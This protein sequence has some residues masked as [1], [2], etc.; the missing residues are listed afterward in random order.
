MGQ[1][2][3]GGASAGAFGL[4]LAAGP[5]V[6]CL[7]LQLDCRRTRRRWGY[8][9]G[10]RTGPADDHTGLVAGPAFVAD[11]C[12]LTAVGRGCRDRSV[13]RR[14]DWGWRPARLSFAGGCGLTAV[15]RA[16]GG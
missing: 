14:S 15:A 8:G 9:R 5:A 16:A 1:G 4:G 11:G 12:G 13:R 7:R 10:A 6:V 2:L 3:R